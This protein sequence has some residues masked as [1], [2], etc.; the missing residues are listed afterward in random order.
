MIIGLICLDLTTKI[1]PKTTVR[2]SVVVKELVLPDDEDDDE[3]VIKSGDNLGGSLLRCTVIREELR[4]FRAAR[5]SL[6]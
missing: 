6:N 4:S 3:E 1:F 2:F 5:F